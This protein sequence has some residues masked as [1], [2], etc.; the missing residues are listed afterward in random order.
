MKRGEGAT[1]E[2]GRSGGGGRR[3]RTRRILRIWLAVAAAAIAGCALGVALTAVARAGQRYRQPRLTPNDAEKGMTSYPHA[4][5]VIYQN[6]FTLKD[7]KDSTVEYVPV[8]KSNCSVVRELWEEVRVV[9]WVMTQPRNHAT[10]AEAVKET[11]GRR[12]NALVFISTQADASLP[13]VR[14]SVPEGRFNLW[15]KTR[16][17]FVYLHQAGYLSDQVD[18]VL[19]ADDDTFLVMENLRYLL[20][21]Y[22]PEKTVY[23]G[24]RFKAHLKQ[25]F[26]SGGTGYVLSR[27]AARRFVTEGLPGN[28][29]CRNYK[30]TYEDVE[31]GRCMA[32]LGAEFVDA[33]DSDGRHRF[34]PYQPERHLSKGEDTKLVWLKDYLSSPLNKGKEC[35]SPLAIS[36]HYVTPS[37]MREMYYLVYHLTPYGIRNKDDAADHATH[38][39]NTTLDEIDVIA[40]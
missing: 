40:C 34:F 30:Q 24:L 5:K 29:T 2:S 13:T 21:Q 15:D 11:W 8:K 38:D 16:A 33:R 36:F 10:K 1:R 18:W 28:K 32:A 3:R 17:A 12:C 23:V 31:M 27:V 7:R 20:T 26:M 39:A 25:G 35:C 37:R 14:V 22:D 9:C 6:P 4:E 19:K